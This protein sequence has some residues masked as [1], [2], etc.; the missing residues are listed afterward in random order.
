MKFKLFGTE[1]YVS[2]FFLATVTIMFATDKTGLILPMLSAIFLHE[3]AHL[4]V[5]WRVGETP[6]K[7]RLIPASVQIVNSG[8]KSYKNEVKIA[9]AGPVFNLIFFAFF[10]HFKGLFLQYF[11]VINLGFGV[12]NLLPLKGLDGGVILHTVLCRIFDIN[13]AEKTL[14]TVSLTFGFLSIFGAIFLLLRGDFNLSFFI[15]GVYLVL[16][17]LLKA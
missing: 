2:F 4:F 13:I 11:A 1:I 17:C 8:F 7:I 14:K 15:M 3:S 5:M 10:W 6:R 9:L 16:I 12:F